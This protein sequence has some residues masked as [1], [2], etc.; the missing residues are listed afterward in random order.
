M[1]A[2]GEEAVAADVE[3]QRAR[4]A[5]ERG[6]RGFPADIAVKIKVNIAECTVVQTGYFEGEKIG[7]GCQSMS[8]CERQSCKISMTATFQDIQVGIPCMVYYYV[9]GFGLK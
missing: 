1:Q 5:V 8:L 3:W 7:S 2:F 6:E 4:D 9:A